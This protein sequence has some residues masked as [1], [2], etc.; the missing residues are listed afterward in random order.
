MTRIKEQYMKNTMS[1]LFVVVLGIILFGKP[2]LAS[3]FD[4]PNDIT[5]QESE[6]RFINIE[7][8]KVANIVDFQY[9]LNTM[10][11]LELKNIKKEFE[12]KTLNADETES[13][14]IINEKISI[15][16]NIE[17]E[18]KEAN[19]KSEQKQT[20]NIIKVSVFYV[21]LISVLTFLIICFIKRKERNLKLKSNM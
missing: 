20:L 3:A 8:N 6:E 21:T 16:E 12:N 2:T 1:K 5:N 4:E 13:L 18:I 19:I 11:I 17:K 10:N 7:E 9:K 14:R 15:Q